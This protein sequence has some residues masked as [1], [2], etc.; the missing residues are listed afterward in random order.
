MPCG[1][2]KLWCILFFILICKFT[3]EQAIRQ[4]RTRSTNAELVTDDNDGNS[5]KNKKVLLFLIMVD[6]SGN[7][8]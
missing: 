4:G 2:S 6:I 3:F 5:V 7:V 8:Q 1:E